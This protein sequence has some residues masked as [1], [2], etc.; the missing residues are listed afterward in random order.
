MKVKVLVD[1]MDCSPPGSSVHGIF[2]AR[3]L[4]YVAFPSPGDLPIP[5]TEPDSL[6]SEPPRKPNVNE[7][8]ENCDLPN[9]LTS[10][11]APLRSWGE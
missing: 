9:P 3:I 1:L 5:E 6:T 2:Q 4:E 10:L 8:S 7:G 11:P